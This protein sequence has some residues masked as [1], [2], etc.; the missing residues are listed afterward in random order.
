MVTCIRPIQ[1][2]TSQNSGIRGGGTLHTPN[3]TEQLLPVDSFW[4]QE[5][6][7]FLKMWSLVGFLCN[8]RWPFFHVHMG[9]TK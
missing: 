3:L 4:V 8:S 1:H 7:S 5:S 2:E 9:S 6:H